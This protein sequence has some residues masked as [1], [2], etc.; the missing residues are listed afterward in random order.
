M[1]GIRRGLC[2][3][4]WVMGRFLYPK[5]PPRRYRQSLVRKHVECYQRW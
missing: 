1:A 2:L 5:L 4:L 3:D